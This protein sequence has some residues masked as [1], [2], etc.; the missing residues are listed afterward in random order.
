MGESSDGIRASDADRGRTVTLLQHHFE[1][2]R[3]TVLEFE[4]RTRQAYASRTLGDLAALLADLPAEPVPEPVVPRVSRQGL[5]GQWAHYASVSL[6]LVGIW[7]LSG[8]GYFWPAWPMLGW[9]FALVSHALRAG[10]GTR[11]HC[12]AH[13]R[14]WAASSATSTTTWPPR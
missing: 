14:A 8:R 2:G 1:V 7:A 6:L 9:G 5:Q 3:L 11:H 10:D 12:R 4:D 13:R